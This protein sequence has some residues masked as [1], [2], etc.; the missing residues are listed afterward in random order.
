[1]ETTTVSSKYQI[2]IPQKIRQQ[3]HIHPGQQ[4]QVISYGDRIELIPVRS[5]QELRGF[6]KGIDMTVEREE[7]RV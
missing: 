4:L 1:M 6:L 2:V 3:M 5:P 7:D